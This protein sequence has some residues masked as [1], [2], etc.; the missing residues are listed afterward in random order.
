MNWFET[1]LSTAAFTGMYLLGSHEGK[2]I[3]R[4]KLADESQN[5]EINRLREELYQLRRARYQD[6]MDELRM[7]LGLP[8]K[9]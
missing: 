4:K 6:P 2:K 1:L 5:D 9:S 3:E 8:Y 7:K